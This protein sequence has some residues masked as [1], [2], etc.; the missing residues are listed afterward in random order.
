MQK[1]LNRKGYLQPVGIVNDTH[2]NQTENRTK[3]GRRLIQEELH[4][5]I[6]RRTD[7]L[8]ENTQKLLWLQLN[9]K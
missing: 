1:K 4:L 6:I 9:V 2:N 5:E 8:E 7:Y 3:Y